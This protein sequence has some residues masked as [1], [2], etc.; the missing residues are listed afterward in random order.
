M[1]WRLVSSL[2]I[3][4]EKQ[5]TVCRKFYDDP[6]TAITWFYILFAVITGPI[7]FRVHKLQ[8]CVIQIQTLISEYLPI[9]RQHMSCSFP[10]R[11]T[12][13]T[14]TATTHTATTHTVTTHTAT[15]HTATTH[16]ATTHCNNTHCNNTP[17]QHTL[18]QHTPQRV[19]S[20]F[21]EHG[22]QKY[23][24]CQDAFNCVD[25]DSRESERATI[26]AVTDCLCAK[27]S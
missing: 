1:P 14:H 2:R 6:R 17:Q 23:T 15:T 8:R 25:L 11:D 9:R 4:A 7:V 12:A 3:K 19:S 22:G 27:S 20:A 26:G 5:A 16:T 10:Q 21:I 24:I 13:T 18:Q